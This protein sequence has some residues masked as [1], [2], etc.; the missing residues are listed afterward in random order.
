MI[1]AVVFDL[2]DTLYEYENLNKIA[3]EVVYDRFADVLNLSKDTLRTAIEWGKQETKNTMHDCASRHNRMIYFQKASEYL[4]LNP[5][6][7]TLSM[8]ETYW[9]YMLE[10]M[11][12]YPGVLSLFDHLKRN[13]IKIAICTD[14]TVNIQHRKLRKL[15]IWSYID[16]LVTSEEADAE[17]PNPSM[18]NLVLRKLG[19]KAGEALYVGD[20]LKKDV[21]GASNVGMQACWFCATEKHVSCPEWYLTVK[22]FGEIEKVIFHERFFE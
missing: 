13:Q 11:K 19:I 20:S 16:A 2:D 8:Y 18:F 9:N 14:L 6:E 21:I 15:G 22:S 7:Y 5:V 12:L 10:N 17:K 4:H 1:K 3:I